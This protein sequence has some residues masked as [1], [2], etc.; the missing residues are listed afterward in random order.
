MKRALL[1]FSTFLVLGVSTQAHALLNGSR[2]TSVT[3]INDSTCAITLDANGSGLLDIL[4]L[5]QLQWNGS[6]LAN[7][8]VLVQRLVS[9]DLTHVHEVLVASPAFEA[10]T[11]M[12]ADVHL[13]NE[14][15][16]ELQVGDVLRIAVPGLLGGL[17]ILDTVNLPEGFGDLT[18]IL[19]D[20]EGN[21]DLLH[22]VEE[23]LE[24]V[25]LDTVGTI[26]AGNGNVGNPPQS[27]GPE[28]GGVGGSGDS[29]SGDGVVGP[30]PGSAA[31][32]GCS[33]GA[34]APAAGL[35]LLTWVGAAAAL[36]AS[37]KRR[38]P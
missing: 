6:L 7:L 4:S 3:K 13:D 25:G 24:I 5:D 36:I 19:I 11:G 21:I 38:Q 15:C 20:E 31:S 26:G 23:V 1:I 30:L 12:T 29:E 16:S 9:L 33:L 35:E 32:G 37:R 18:S 27:Q 14:D 17:D 34:S 28:D 22:L 8:G 2:I 10:L